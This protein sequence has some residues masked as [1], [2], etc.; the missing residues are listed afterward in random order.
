MQR[1]SRSMSCSQI[2]ASF[3]RCKRS[4]LSFLKL[5]ERAPPAAAPTACSIDTPLTVS[6]HT[7]APQGCRQC[8][9]DCW[10]GSNQPVVTHVPPLRFEPR[11]FAHA[12]D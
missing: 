5:C 10:G 2:D 8:E 12:A 6:V 4:S 7:L 11:S 1:F 3:C 9:V